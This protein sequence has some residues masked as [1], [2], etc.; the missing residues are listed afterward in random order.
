MSYGHMVKSEDELKR[1]IEALL[2]RAA[3]ADEA[4]AQEPEVDIPAEIARREA[5][6]AAIGAA[7]ARLE[8]R[9]R[10]QDRQE[11]RHVD[12][13]GN[14][15]RPWRWG[16]QGPAGYAAREGARELH[17]PGQPHHE[18]RWREL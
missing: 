16:I 11:G 10:E 13:Q 15:P 8:K 6:L 5:R 9:Q 12:D 7:W 2:R 17:R 1:Q 14:N 4:E 3:Q 18:A